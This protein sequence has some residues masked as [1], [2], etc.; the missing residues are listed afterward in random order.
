MRLDKNGVFKED[1]G[2]ISGDEY[3]L[4]IAGLMILFMFINMAVGNVA[5]SIA[6]EKS[7]RVIEYLL[8]G[9]RPMA[10]LSGKIAARLLESF[11]TFFAAYSSYFLSQ[12]VCM[13]FI[14]GRATSESVSDNMVVVAGIWETITLSKVLVALVYFMAGLV[15][16]TLIGAVTG[17]SVS[18]LDELQEA[19]RFFTFLLLVCVYVD[20]F[21]IIMM[22]TSGEYDT[23]MYFCSI[24]PLT[25]AFLTPAL[26]LTGKISLLI[27]V[28]ALVIIIIA[29]IA[30][31]MFVA[32]VY[33]SMLLFQGKRLKGKDVI[34]I[35]KKQVVA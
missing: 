20:M 7:S 35:M 14:A 28:I 2:G 31:F 29:A 8:T 11:I 34:A 24:F 22:L 32:A 16:Y 18:K 10:L 26:I 9:T 15:L 17:A 23:F 30:T 4:M 27:G 5:T 21:L 3:F 33:E 12:L 6:T 25:G 19:Y 1:E 13:F